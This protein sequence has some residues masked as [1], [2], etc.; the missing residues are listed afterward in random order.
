MNNPLVILERAL[1]T[2]QQDEVIRVVSLK[3]DRQLLDVF[4]N[5]DGEY[6]QFVTFDGVN[7]EGDTETIDNIIRTSFPII[8]IVKVLPNGSKLQLYDY[9]TNV[10]RRIP[11][12]RRQRT[13]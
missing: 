5:R 6:I 9:I 1:H 11:N 2:L 13:H 7:L 3:N 8:N 12:S 4:S 10:Q